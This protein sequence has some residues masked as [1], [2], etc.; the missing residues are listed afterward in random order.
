MLNYRLSILLHFDN[1]N[2]QFADS[3]KLFLNQVT[4]KNEKKIQNPHF[5]TLLKVPLS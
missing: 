4:L 2:I 1:A 5:L 3:E